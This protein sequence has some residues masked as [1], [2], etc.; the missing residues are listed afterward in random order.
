MKELNHFVPGKGP[1]A[2]VKGHIFFTKKAL[3]QSRGAGGGRNLLNR[4][5]F[6]NSL[7]EIK[8]RIFFSKRAL[9]TKHPIP[10]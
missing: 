9:L 2:S 10:G 6:L 1:F 5:L 7:I 4:K 8:K 3:R